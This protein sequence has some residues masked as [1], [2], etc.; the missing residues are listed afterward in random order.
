MDLHADFQKIMFCLYFVCVLF[1]RKTP[2]STREGNRNDSLKARFRFTTALG[3]T[4]SSFGSM[5][6]SGLLVL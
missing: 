3:L 5:R 6:D 2:V 4:T 1:H